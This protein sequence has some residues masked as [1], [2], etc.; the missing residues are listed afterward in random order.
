MKT[1]I[2]IVAEALYLLNIN[3]FTTKGDDTLLV[4]GEWP[5]VSNGVWF[6]GQRT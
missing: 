4:F 3:S 6:E 2:P 5:Y 1:D